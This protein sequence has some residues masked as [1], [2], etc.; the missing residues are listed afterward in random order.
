MYIQLRLYE[1]ECGGPRCV[2]RHE[3][4]THDYW[5]RPSFQAG[6]LRTQVHPNRICQACVRQR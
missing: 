4:L 6:F 5:L 1:V 2:G 3:E